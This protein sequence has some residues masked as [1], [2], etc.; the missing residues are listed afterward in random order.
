MKHPATR[1]LKLHAHVSGTGQAVVFLHGLFGSWQNLG[2]VIRAAAEHYQVHAL[3]LRNHGKSAHHPNHD[4]PALAAD[5]AVYI[6]ERIGQP[7][8]V[9]GHSMGG[10]TAM[11]LALEYPEWVSKLAVMDIAPRAYP[12][13]HDEILRGMRTMQ[14]QLYANRGEADSAL[15]QWVPELAIRHFLLKNL[16]L[17]E[18]VA[19]WRANLA[20]I[21]SEYPHIA[22]WP[23]TESSYSGPVLFL[24]GELSG[25]IV[26][27]DKEETLRL[28]PE[29][30]VKTIAATGH[31]LH[32]EKPVVFNK[33]LLDFLAK[34]PA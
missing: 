29:A 12:S 27:T 32:A 18:G 31:W 21:I 28:F 17:K 20:V 2:S 30:Q 4:Y 26:A 23:S 9:V 16:I 11:L 7:C 3:D 5:V 19:S 24:R 14:G 34:D 1:P 15:S 22:G 8:Y 10:K 6:E 33:L 25:Y 13:H